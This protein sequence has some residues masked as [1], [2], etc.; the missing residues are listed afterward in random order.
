MLTKEQV[1]QQIKDNAMVAVVRG[2]ILFN[3]IPLLY[4]C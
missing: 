2:E 3:M 4:V 1:L